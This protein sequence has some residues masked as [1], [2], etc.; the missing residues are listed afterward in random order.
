MNEMLHTKWINKKLG[1][2]LQ[3]IIAGIVKKKFSNYY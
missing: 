2:L 1:K 3:K